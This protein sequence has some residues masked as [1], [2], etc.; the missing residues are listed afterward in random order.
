MRESRIIII[1]LT[2]A[3]ILLISILYILQLC[4]IDS[5]LS[6]NIITNLECGAIVGLITAICQYCSSKRKIV[7]GIYGAYF[8]LYRTYYYSKNHSFLLHHNSYS[9][10]K[11]MI[12]LNPKI[13][14]ILDEYHGLL[15]EHDKTYKKLNP[16]INMDGNYKVKTML[17]SILYLFNKKSF[18]KVFEPFIK[19]IEKI[20]IDINSKRFEKDKA[21]MIKLHNY[22]YDINE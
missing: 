10:F 8:D 17:K 18:D 12:D 9:I 22:M 21:N 6:I 2:I 1:I 20:L 4:G 13:I 19:E 3:M 16:I 14:E 7:N 15:K 11:K 5:D